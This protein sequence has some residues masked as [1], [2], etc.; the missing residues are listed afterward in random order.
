MLAQVDGAHMHTNCYF[1]FV[2]PSR[3]K[4]THACVL[5]SDGG[6]A[7]LAGGA[8]NIFNTYTHGL[9]ISLCKGRR[10]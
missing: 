8:E 6:R 5:L 2:K 3:P 9:M 1:W 10:T 7:D 4:I